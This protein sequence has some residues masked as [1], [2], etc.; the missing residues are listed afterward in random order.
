MRHINA[1]GRDLIK[2]EEAL[3]LQA[4]LC[5]AGVPTI[6]YGHTRGV[7]IGQ[8]ITE[9]QAEQFLSDDLAVAEAGVERLAPLANDNEFSALVSFAFNLGVHALERSTLMHRFILGDKPGAANCFA[10]WCHAIDPHT[11]K[12]VSLPG[13]VRRRAEEAA[14]FLRPVHGGGALATSPQGATPKAVSIETSP[15][16]A[17]KPTT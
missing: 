9:A 4:Y 13:L 11:G 15:P 17:V 16:A 3:R 7:A 10:A 5:P 14:L 2:R 8:T 1:A 12:M 6:G